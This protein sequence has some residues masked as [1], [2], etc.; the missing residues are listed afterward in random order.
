M[1][2]MPMMSGDPEEELYRQYGGLL[3]APSGGL[4]S[5]QPQQPVPQ[6]PPQSFGQR[7][8]AGLKSFAGNRDLALAL[9]SNS[10]Y[11][12]KRSF[13]EILG[14]SAM[15]ADQMKQ[16]RAD[17]DLNQQYKQAQ[18]QHLQQPGGANQPASVAEYQFAKQNGFTGSFQEWL[19]RGGGSETADIQNYNFRNGLTPEQ[20]KVWDAQKRQPT[21]PQLTMIN[22]VPHL[23]DR[24][25]GSVTPLSD[26]A[27]TTDA[28]AQV[29][30]AEASGG[31]QGKIEGERAVKNPR[32][33]ETFK[34]GMASLEKAMSATNTGPFVGRVPAMTAAQ[35]TAEGSE[36]IMAPVLKQLFRESGEGT[37]TDSDQALLMKMVPTRKDHPEARKAKMEMIDSIVRAKLGISAGGS[38]SATPTGKRPAGKPAASGGKDPLGIR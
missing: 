31:A 38:V 37:F 18:I 25:T 35:Q 4:L 33:Y 28:A 19:A 3:G 29:A 9:L 23:V 34:A 21:A 24:I 6:Q 5:A 15:Q 30:A 17:A 36:A 27:Q 20:Q 7:L 11:G 22:G 13:G 14:T 16:Q 1:S 2:L 12:P 32:S 8:G 26:L 10:G